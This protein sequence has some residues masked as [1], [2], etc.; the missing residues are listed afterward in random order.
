MNEDS[1]LNISDP[2]STALT[3]MKLRAFIS[4][5]ARDPGRAPRKSL[6]VPNRMRAQRKAIKR[7]SM[8]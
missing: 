4:A 6:L 5:V 3:T 8:P 2:L 1:V 7:S